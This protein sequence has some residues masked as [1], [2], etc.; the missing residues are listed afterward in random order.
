MNIWLIN[1][2][3]PLPGDP[4]QQGRY[5][6]LARMLIAHG[7]KVLWWTSSFSHRFKGDVDQKTITQACSD[8][9]IDVVFLEGVAYKTNVGFSR[10]RNH[11]QLARAF[12][13]QANQISDKPDVV[14]VSAP[15][16]FLA[17]AA[18]CYASQNNIRCMIDIQDLWPETFYRVAP[19]WLKPLLACV[20]FPWKRASEKA[21][22]NASVV[23]GVADE[24]VNS[25]LKLGAAPQET[26]TIPLGIDLSE[27]DQAAIQGKT[28]CFVKDEDEIWFAYTGSLN[29]SYDCL[30]LAKAFLKVN[31]QSKCRMKLFITGRGELS[32]SLSRMIQEANSNDVIQTGFLD[33]PQWA[34]LLNQ[35]DVGFN[36]SFPEAMIYLPNKIFYYFA[37]SLAVLNTIPG[38]CS[39]I[40][41]DSNSGFDYQAGDVQSCVE[42]ILTI[43][44]NTDKLKVMKH[45]SRLQAENIYDR[46]IL[47][48]KYVALIE[49]V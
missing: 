25:A 40:V 2:F 16:P 49:Q 13:A 30:T 21:Y 41:K 14:L 38:Q 7:H 39:A 17:K 10:L 4:E 35:C 44:E 33:F 46:N 47:Y 18:M 23:V 26:A 31:H 28:D 9:G 37:A 24:Y 6:T 3:D 32:E 5:A 34:Y 12:T 22:K 20:F 11:I 42:A 1:P 19:V 29:R 48:S 15:P 45:H 27:F 43:L 36:A 8:I